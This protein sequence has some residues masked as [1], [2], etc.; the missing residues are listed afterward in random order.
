M[1][2]D[3]HPQAVVRSHGRQVAKLAASTSAASSTS[4][5]ARP[6]LQLAFPTGSRPARY[7]TAQR[8]GPTGRAAQ[9]AVDSIRAHGKCGATRPFVA[10]DAS[11]GRGRPPP[12]PH[13]M[14]IVAP[15]PAPLSLSSSMPST[16]AG[17]PRSNQNSPSVH[18]DRRH[19]L[20]LVCTF[21][22]AT[23]FTL[24]G[25]PRSRH[26]RADHGALRTGRARLRAQR[27]RH[28][29]RRDDACRR[30]SG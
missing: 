16:I 25:P 2:K 5:R 27:P 21:D 17:G 18:L 15:P 7:S 10:A 6:R 9:V 4:A 29:Y 26:P 3:S 1:T 12:Q 19:T 20:V 22:V 28:Q 14:T 8:S 24:R 13:T 23:C 30:S 11:P